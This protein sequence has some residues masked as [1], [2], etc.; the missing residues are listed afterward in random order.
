MSIAF[1]IFLGKLDAV[2][3]MCICLKPTCLSA[4]QDTPMPTGQEA[5]CLGNLTTLT[6]CTKYLPPN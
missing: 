6:S 3:E 5:P 2:T 4:E 1:Q